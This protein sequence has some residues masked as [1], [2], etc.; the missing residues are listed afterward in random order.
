MAD[1]RTQ[2]MIVGG[3]GPASVTV[4]LPTALRDV[5]GYKVKVIPGYDG[6]NV[7]AKALENGEVD[8]RCGWSYPS[9][10]STHAD[11][12]ASGKVRFL[13][14]VART[15]IPQ[16]PDVPTVYELAQTDQQRQVLALALAG[17]DMARPFMAPPDVPDDR[18]AALRA[19]F[20]AAAKDPEF[21]NRAQKLGL[22]IDPVGWREMR[23]EIEQLHAT[24]APIVEIVRRLIAGK[25]L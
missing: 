19:A 13:A 7:I 4:V 1:L 24:P 18:L 6:G 20:D 21:L 3:T 14:A 9:L 25:P 22:E 16:L 10:M 2:E 8:G 15:R 17:E 5:L 11:W 23:D 12:A